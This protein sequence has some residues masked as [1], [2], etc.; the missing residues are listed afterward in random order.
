MRPL[1]VKILKI[2]GSVFL[3]FVAVSAF[4]PLF[5]M[6]HPAS[7]GSLCVS[8][9]KQQAIGLLIDAGDHDER[10]TPRAAWMDAI[11]PYVRSETILRDPEG[12]KGGY[13]Y[14]DAALSA[15]E[16]P[17]AAAT[18]PMVYDST[19]PARNASDRFTSL[20]NPG[21]H[22]GTNNVAYAEGHVRR[23][24]IR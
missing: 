5:A 23:V 11:Q 19:D 17:K 1:E 22:R 3:L 9:L 12:P 21:R 20:P 18:T 15:T 16:T 4:F 10:L 14:A 2:L 7:P 6:G 8:R 13:G 24:A